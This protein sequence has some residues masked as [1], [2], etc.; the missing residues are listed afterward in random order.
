MRRILMAAA[1]MAS[2]LMLG[3]SASAEETVCRGT[4]G[5]RTVDNLR[6]PQG[7]TCHLNGTRVE[8]T[9]KVGRNAT[10]IARDIR[11]IGN[12]QGEN[13]R[14]VV[15]KAGSRVNGDIQHVQGEAAQVLDS[16]IGGDLLFDENDGFLAARRN[17]IGEDLQA[18]QNT[19]G[20]AIA[21]NRIQ[22]NLQCKQNHPPPT[23][24][25]NVVHGNKEDQCKRL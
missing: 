18:F 14:K 7:E 2:V 22:G 3:P 5:G 8:G 25:G 15:V 4:I 6:V 10:L 21:Q 23:G 19:A 9:V 11:V 20:V 13:S 17:R 24:G 1:M 12:V 16:V